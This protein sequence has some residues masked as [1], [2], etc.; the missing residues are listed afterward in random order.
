MSE[1]V[2]CISRNNFNDECPH[3]RSKNVDERMISD[4]AVPISANFFGL[5]DTS[6][7]FC[8]D[9]REVFLLAN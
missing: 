1:N 3:C 4:P 7:R 8:F 5:S 9:C 2:L 6:I